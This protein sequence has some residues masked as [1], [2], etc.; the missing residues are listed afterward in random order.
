MTSGP[1]WT[2]K[3][4]GQDGEEGT[5]IEML[6]DLASSRE[7]S[8]SVDSMAISGIVYRV[9]AMAVV[10]SIAFAQGALRTSSE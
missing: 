8:V 3:S 10:S 1:T 7:A 2:N 9:K 6:D 5:H 4:R